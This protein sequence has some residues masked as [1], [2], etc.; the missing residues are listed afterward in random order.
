MTGLF[1]VRHRPGSDSLA[2]RF[3]PLMVE[4]F[5]AGHL[6]PTPAVVVSRSRVLPRRELP[7]PARLNG[8]ERCYP[9][10][11]QNPRDGISGRTPRTRFEPQLP[12]GTTPP[13]FSPVA[14]DSRLKTSKS[15][16]RPR[17]LRRTA[18]LPYEG[19]A[20]PPSGDYVG[21]PPSN[22]TSAYRRIR[23][24]GHD[25]AGCDPYPL[26]SVVAEFTGCHRRSDGRHEQ[27]LI[28]PDDRRGRT[29]APPGIARFENQIH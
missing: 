3:R 13:G 14:R 17:L 15:D 19:S 26:S 6:T 28:V 11:A 4:L 18:R 23:L 2:S 24:Y 21:Q 29:T 12:Q 25:A 5:A 10:L 7:T 22:R 1:P 8:P 9:P 20:G 27:R 16:R